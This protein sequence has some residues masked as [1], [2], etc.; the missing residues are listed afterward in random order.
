MRI[1]KAPPTAQGQWVSAYETERIIF[2]KKIFT[3]FIAFFIIFSLSACAKNRPVQEPADNKDIKIEEGTDTK[4]EVSFSSYEGKNKDMFLSKGDRIAV[5]APSSRPSKEQTDAT[6]KGLKDWGYTPVAGS[7]VYDEICSIEDLIEDLTW[8]LEDPEIRAI[9]CVR[10]GYGISEVMDEIPLDLIRDSGKLVLGYSDITV[11]HSAWSCADLPSIHC[12]MS[13]TFDYLP[14]GCVEA[15]KALLKGSIPEYTCANNKYCRQGECDGMLIG[16]N[17]STF[18][19]VLGSDYD[20]TATDE[21]YILFLEDVGE[22]LQHIHRYLTILKHSGALDNASGIIF[23]EWTDLPSDL[24]DY[25]GSSRGEAFGS[26]ADMISRQFLDDL[27]IP[28]A[29][30][31]PAGHGDTNYP[32]LMG[33]DAHLSVNRDSYTISFK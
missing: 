12:C 8:A 29:F 15:E 18:C 10:G 33:T 24:G 19:S 2:M 9:F 31:F 30:G 13:G 6:I 21:P 11:L 3:V 4:C 14:E 20:I 32:L 1:Y 5:I 27:D 7:H 16:G 28:V 17:L 22:D 25:T 26:V 23:G